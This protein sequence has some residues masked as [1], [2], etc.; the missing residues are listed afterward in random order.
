MN[1]SAHLH[2]CTR[3]FIIDWLL[4]IITPKIQPFSQVNRTAGVVSIVSRVVSSVI[5]SVV[6]RVTLWRRTDVYR[7]KL[8]RFL[9]GEDF[10]SSSLVRKKRR[11]ER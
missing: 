5:C 4:S 2:Q 7:K 11:K 8:K 10:V 6:V 3:E 9:H 1:T